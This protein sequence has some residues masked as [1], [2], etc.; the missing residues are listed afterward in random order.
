MVAILLACLR[1]VSAIYDTSCTTGPASCIASVNG[2]R[3]IGS[4][5]II[6]KWFGFGTVV[7]VV[8]L[9]LASAPVFGQEVRDKAASEGA[10]PP[11][12]PQAVHADAEG[13]IN[14]MTIAGL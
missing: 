4:R 1:S 10:T 3:V 7:A 14:D 6:M 5:R 13:F 2:S 9:A 8:A 11:P 12:S